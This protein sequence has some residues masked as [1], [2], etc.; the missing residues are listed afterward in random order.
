LHD[1]RFFTAYFES[2]Y[3]RSELNAA[4]ATDPLGRRGRVIPVRVEPVEIPTFLGQLAYLDLVGV[5]E[6]TARQRLMITLV[7]HGQV[8]PAKV[9]LVG[10]APRAVEQANRNRRAMIEKVRAIWIKGF[11]EKSLFNEIR[12]VLGLVER[13][14]AVASPF[15]LLVKRPDEG[16]RPLPPGTQ[17]LD[18]YDNSDES[19]LILGEPG[20][21]KTTLLLEL[22]RDL[23][24]RADRDATHPIPVVFPLSTWAVSR[25]PIIEWLQEELNLR[26]DVPR[27]IAHEWVDNDRV[28]PLLD[29]LDEVKAEHRA[30]CVEAINAFR[31][32]H[33]FLPVVISSRTAD[34]NALADPVRVYGAI[35]VQPMK[36][37]QVDAYLEDL[38]HAAEPIRVAMR[39]D[40]ALWALLESPLML[41][42]VMMAFGGESSAKTLTTG[43]L[44]ER[45]DKLLQSYVTQMLHRRPFDRSRSPD[46]TVHRLR[47]LA[48]RMVNHGQQQFHL[49]WLQPEWFP[50][51]QR[52]FINLSYVFVV[53]VAAA[54][55]FALVF[56]LS[57]AI[58]ELTSGAPMFDPMFWLDIA[59]Q[60][61]IVFGLGVALR[62]GAS[63]RDSD[64]QS[65]SSKRGGGSARRNLIVA[66]ISA[67]AMGVI[68]VLD[69]GWG[70]S[71]AQDIFVGVG[72]GLLLGAGPSLIYGLFVA[73]ADRHVRTI[74]PEHRRWSW[75]DATQA[76][77][78]RARKI[79][80]T[81]LISGVAVGS[82]MAII[83]WTDPTISSFSPFDLAFI[84][85]S[86][87][88][89]IALCGALGLALMSG[90]SFDEIPT[91]S[92]PNQ[93]IRSSARNA[94][95]IGLSSALIL[96]L[97]CV[98][99]IS[100][101]A[102][103]FA[104]FPD[105]L[106]LGG[107][108]GGLVGASGGVAFAL[109]AGGAAYLKHYT[110]RLWLVCERLAPW[111]YARFLNHAADQVLLRKVGGGYMFIHRMLM[112]W[113]AA[114]YVEPSV[115]GNEPAKPSS[116]EHEL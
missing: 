15:H 36:S 67:I 60:I 34:Y 107:L 77:R 9:D 93:G 69:R 54:A 72:A 43:T 50:R 31:H 32:S 45:R 105:G 106:F 96:V 108:L 52:R 91:R 11:L 109:R 27:V 61:G 101:V 1:C 10:R 49:E 87:A 68:I 59:W 33:G 24:D 23:L 56:G 16:E 73:F 81:G 3:T 57:A 20:S 86:S 25:K 28:V 74:L 84:A 44:A 7:R 82:A 39:E 58:F 64:A 2:E 90:W 12:I 115:G 78:G 26:Y 102:L 70:H 116:I 5:N 62:E 71:V 4:L 65:P 79:V 95:L 114:R 104:S 113:F 112:E 89:C 13:P 76:I 110:L 37:D 92:A 14:S 94:G 6:E 17:V 40:P 53:A 85:G 41:N 80:I 75:M 99:P 35:C 111:N 30:G 66:S 47:W 29:G 8:D 48:S 103:M 18:V 46:L 83:L 19:L 98:L 63:F 51:S 22:A 42:V 88:L 100:V 38:G 97:G 21:G 55:V